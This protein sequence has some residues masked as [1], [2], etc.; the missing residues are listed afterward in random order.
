M[1]EICA[2]ELGKVM[3]VVRGPARVGTKCTLPEPGSWSV[4]NHE[5]ADT[6]R[7]SPA[8]ETV[9]GVPASAVQKCCGR[10]CRHC[11]VYRHRVRP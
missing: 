5:P 8:S 9:Y 4:E 3:T 7:N 2:T 11:R 6:A 1:S 10:G